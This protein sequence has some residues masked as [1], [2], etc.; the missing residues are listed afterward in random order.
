MFY[1]ITRRIFTGLL[2]LIALLVN[3]TAT[4][5]RA[6]AP[7][8]A[9]TVVYADTACGDLK[10]FLPE[11][12]QDGANVLLTI[13]GGGWFSG[14]ASMF[15]D[16]CRA[17][18]RNGFIAASMNYSK[19]Q[20]GVGAE[21]MANEV[22]LAVGALKAA[23]ESR[24]IRPGKLILAGHSAGAHIMLLYA[25]AHAKDCPMEIAFL[26][27]NSA[28]VEFLSDPK[29]R[30]TLLGMF[31]Y[32]LLSCFT[33]EVV[34]PSTVEKNREAI[35]RVSPLTLVTG[36]VPPTI[37]VQGDA[38]DFVPFGNSVM[39]Y[40]ALQANGVDSEHIVYPGAGHFLGVKYVDGNTA[41]TEAFYTF[42]EKYGG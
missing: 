12:V 35:D 2:A 29:T 23:L 21:D 42:L 39:L 4:P 24:G 15:Y 31:A 7:Y 11:D 33:K 27:S 3:A 22:G 28:P 9:L 36:D 34:T 19:L 30:T 16:D 5:T 20:N 17:A 8:D 26:V 1:K 38:D 13:P 10:L 18:A 32:P 25:Y 40:D 14:N 41:R 6:K 37:V